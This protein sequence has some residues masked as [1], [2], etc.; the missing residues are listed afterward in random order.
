MPWLRTKCSFSIESTLFNEVATDEEME[1]SIKLFTMWKN[2]D[3][4]PYSQELRNHLVR[5]GIS[6]LASDE[7]GLQL[8]I[9]D[10][11]EELR[12]WRD[13]ALHDGLLNE[14]Q[15]AADALGTVNFTADEWEHAARVTLRLALNL[16]QWHRSH[17]P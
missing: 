2:I 11:R 14:Y 3:L 6:F 13:P 7:E 10:N 12:Q 17:I 16:L 5:Q 8:E 15:E 9:D 4:A 1:L